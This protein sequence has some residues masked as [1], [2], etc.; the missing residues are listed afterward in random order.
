LEQSFDCPD[1]PASLELPNLQRLSSIEVHGFVTPT[2]APAVIWP[3]SDAAPRRP[4]ASD[5]PHAPAP[6]VAP[7]VRIG[8]LLVLLGVYLLLA[9]VCP[10]PAGVAPAAWRITAVFLT[11]IAGLMLQPLPG[12]ALVI[13]GLTGLVVAGGVPV[14][15]ALSGFATPTV[16]LVL[17]AM[18]MSRVLKATGLARR[19]AL[20]FVR[21]FGRSS[22]GVSYALTMTDVTLAAGIPSIT[23][24]SGSI[25]LPIARG[26][27]E[28][29][30]STPG[31]TA[32]ALGTFLMASLYQT[33]AVACAMFITGQASNV[34]AG[35]LA[36]QYA[37]V[38]VTASSW[39]LAGLAPGLLSC[40]VVP[41]VV[42]RLVPPSI[43]RTPAARDYAQAELTSA[44]AI[45]GKEAV[46]LVVFV[47]VA[48][49][50]LTTGWH[51]LDTT[52]VA[53]AGLSAL[54]IT[55]VLTWEDALAERSAWE[56]FVWYGGLLTMGE[57]LNETGSTTAFAGWIGGA[58]TGLPWFVVLVA[59]LV[60][61]FYA[62]YAFA[63]ITAHVLAMFPPF[64]VMLIQLGAPPAVAVYGLACLANLTAGLTHYGTTTAP[65]VFAE[66]Y[67]SLKDWWRIGLIASTVN[68]VI[69]LVV[70]LA[71]WRVLGYW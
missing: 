4:P 14:T 61:F 40:L 69:W 2:H 18:L 21:Q 66:G 38:T 44:G 62:H 13:V 71:W 64:V 70:G 10:A 31:P 53:L 49:L 54:F 67:V 22:L 24:R 60:V 55:G 12:A 29:Y 51:G 46:A 28:L 25:L 41:L 58:L 45:R 36:G 17:L 20:I 15:R 59:T 23:A 1:A 30:R 37:H 32:P 27:A 57:V 50:W 42:Y 43:T 52:V 3:G 65:M 34:L 11:T 33:S 68:L 8:R 16:W 26:I 7:P 5:L 48:A 6:L 19:I 39:F 35:K 56:I 63:S 47:T 9:H